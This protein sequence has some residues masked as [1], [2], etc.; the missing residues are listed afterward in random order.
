VFRRFFK[1]R[2]KVQSSES[3]DTDNTDKIFAP[4]SL[5]E[6][7]L[8]G[9]REG[10]LVVDKEMRVVASNPAAHK[11]FSSSLKRLDS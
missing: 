9:M 2:E 10:L 6:A 3:Q 5:F 7:T 1:N 8:G 11:L 4:G